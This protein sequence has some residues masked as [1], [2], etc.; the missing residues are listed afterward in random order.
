MSKLDA[1]RNR[2]IDL[3]SGGYFDEDA[4]RRAGEIMAAEAASSQ[5]SGQF[6]Y[7]RYA[8]VTVDDTEAMLVRIEGEP[9]AWAV[10]TASGMAAIDAALSVF[11]DPA[12]DRP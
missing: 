6:V 2:V 9:C 5:S 1:R 11:H 8:N 12:D 4:R 3:T 7:G 10:L